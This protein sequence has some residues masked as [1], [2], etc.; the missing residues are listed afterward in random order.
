MKLP[1]IPLTFL[2]LLTASLAISVVSTAAAATSRANTPQTTAADQTRALVVAQSSD[3][4][5]QR[6]GSSELSSTTA[7][8]NFGNNNGDAD[9]DRG[10]GFFGL[11][12]CPPDRCDHGFDDR[13]HDRDQ[14]CRKHRSGDDGDRGWGGDD[15]RA[16][17]ELFL[18]TAR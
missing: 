9:D 10:C 13:N 16:T 8:T 11:F 6:P 2:G 4:T 14:H 18:A 7:N 12:E 5:Q 3:L 15:S 1:S 17:P